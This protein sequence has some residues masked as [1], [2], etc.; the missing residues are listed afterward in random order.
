MSYRE[1]SSY[2]LDASLHFKNDIIFHPRRECYLFNM[3]VH[4]KNL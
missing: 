2:N 3:N 4:T 1:N